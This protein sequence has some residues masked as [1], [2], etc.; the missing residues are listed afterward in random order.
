MTLPARRAILDLLTAVD[1]V[2]PAAERERA[3]RIAMAALLSQLRPDERSTALDY[4]HWRLRQD[5]S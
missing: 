1:D 3:T 2:E 5:L 4:L